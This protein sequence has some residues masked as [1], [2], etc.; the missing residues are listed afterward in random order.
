LADR[1][2]R[3]QAVVPPILDDDLESAGRSQPV[4][5]RRAQY[6]DERSGHFRV[7]RLGQ[8]VGDHIARQ[9]LPRP[10][11]EVVEHD[12]HG[13]EVRGIRPQH[14]RLPRNGDGMVHSRGGPCDPFEPLHDL[15]CPV[16]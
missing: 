4:D 10:R 11:M 9:V 15:R 16:E 7:E 12:I 2:Q 13:P 1:L 8:S 6:V 3:L 5:G 14:D